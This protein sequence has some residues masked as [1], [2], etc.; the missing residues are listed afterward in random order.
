VLR[1]NHA[2]AGRGH[3]LPDRELEAA[4]VE[5]TAGLGTRAPNLVVEQGGDRRSNY[6]QVRGFANTPL[7]GESVGLHVDGI[8]YADQR[9]SVIPLCDVQDVVSGDHL[10]IAVFGQNL[11]DETYFSFPIPGGPGG[12]FRRGA[13]LRQA[14]LVA[15]LSRTSP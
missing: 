5:T 1:A 9:A 11:T 8:P 3:L 6:V 10:G 13:W 15:A 2:H 12:G 4:L 14:V 7:A